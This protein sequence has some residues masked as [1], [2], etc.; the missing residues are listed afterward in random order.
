M[1]EPKPKIPVVE[2]LIWAV[3]ALVIFGFLAATAPHFVRHQRARTSQNACLNNLRQIDA[4][5]NEFAIEHG[6]TN[7]DPIHYPNDLTPYIKL[8][9]AGQI[10]S[11][12]LGGTYNIAHV[13]EKPTCSLGTTIT[14]V[15]VLP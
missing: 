1:P 14:P 2:I 12:P 10:P 3:A 5:A 4:A 9:S 6:L 11:C 7:G 15:H 13:G 8:N